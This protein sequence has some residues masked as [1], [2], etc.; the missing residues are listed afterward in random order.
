[1]GIERKNRICRLCDSHKIENEYHVFI[2]CKF[3]EGIRLASQIL[4]KDLYE[5]YRLPPQQLGRLISAIHRERLE[6]LKEL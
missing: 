2:A 1:M 6:G 4:V 3:Y 5:L